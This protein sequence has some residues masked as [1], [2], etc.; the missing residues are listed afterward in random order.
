LEEGWVA[1]ESKPIMTRSEYLRPTWIL[2]DKKI[3]IAAVEHETG[4]EFLFDLAKDIAIGVTT[5]IIVSILTK[6]WNKWR[7]SRTSSN[8]SKVEP[9]YIIEYVSEA[10][11][12]GTIKTVKRIEIRGQVSTYKIGD[13][14]AK[15]LNELKEL[16]RREDEPHI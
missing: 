3:Q 14:T 12:D 15:A 4:I 8:P 10:S 11:P 9:S 6:M 13:Q 5:P 1:T 16:N 7:T 2:S